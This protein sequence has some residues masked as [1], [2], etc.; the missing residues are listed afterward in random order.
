[1]VYF[2]NIFNIDE[3]ILDEYGAFNISLLND[4]PLFIDPFLLY[5]S[6]KTEYQ[7]LHNGII[8]YLSFLKKK[9][10]AGQLSDEKIARWYVFPEVKENWLGYSERGNSGSGLGKKFGKAMSSAIVN[11]Y[12][13]I[14][15]ETISHSSHLE[16][17]SLFKSGVGRD[18][19]SD[20]T[21]NLIKKYLLDYTQ[22][23][24]KKHL[25][26]NLCKE[27]SVKKVYFDYE[28]ESWMPSTY[29]LPYFNNSY[30]ILTPKDILTKDE[31]W[32]N[33]T[34]M[35]NQILQIADSIPNEELRD[36][37]NDTYLRSLPPKPKEND[38]SKVVELLVSKF[39]E[40][41]DYYI[42]IKE[43]E[44]EDAILSASS[45]VNNADNMYIKNINKL[46]YQLKNT[47]D[48]YQLESLG[49]FEVTR[50]RVLFLK[51][52]IENRDGYKLFYSNG[53]P[54]SKEKDLQ[55]LF[56][57]TWFA[58]I[59]DVNAEVNNGRGA[60]DFKVSMG[61]IDKTLV[62][63]KLAKSTKL[64]QNLANQVKVYEAANNTHQSL[65]VI[66]FFTENEKNR[67]EKIITK[68][69][70]ENDKNIILIDAINNKISASNVK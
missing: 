25:N 53:K 24:A 11:F 66:L 63:F 28:K 65:K 12:N 14:G 49:T 7:E 68:L 44:K 4:M 21:C 16:K 10:A 13:D 48:F 37:I 45:I 29:Y 30:I 23:F 39:P 60:V 40:I 3:N 26:S 56:K 59:F 50:Q 6:E 15:K 1:M 42:K 34:D 20:F 43:N 2:S 5:A 31:N 8:K 69:G 52:V 9:A 54:I 55:L 47:T 41:M 64:E 62:E 51:D 18:N 61:N 19:I 35:K 22:N 33:F 57:F 32:I 70:L 17:L 67:V 58:S 36:R 46:I 38:V 27:I